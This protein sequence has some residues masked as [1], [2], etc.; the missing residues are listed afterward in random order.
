MERWVIS[1]EWFD[2][3]FVVGDGWPLKRWQPKPDYVTC[4]WLRY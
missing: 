4:E 1:K 2:L 3:V